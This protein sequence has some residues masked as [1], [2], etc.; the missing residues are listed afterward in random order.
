MKILIF[1]KKWPGGVGV[2]V[3]SIKKELEKKGH[4]V[5]C[6]SR[7]EDLKCSSSV[8]NILWLRKKYKEIIEKENPDI[9]YTQD[10]SMALPLIF[11]FRIFK[12]KHFSCFHGNELGKSK[13]LQTV[14][15]KLLG[16]RLIVVGDSLKKRFSK[17]NL[18]YNGV[19]LDLFKPDKKIKKIKNSVGFVNWKTEDYHY[20]EIVSAC[21]E[22]GKNLILAEKI[23][24]EEMPKFYQKLECFIS[25]PPKVTGFNISWIEAMACQVP[26]IIGNSYGVGAKLSI[27]KVKGFK[28]IKESLEKVKKENYRKEI[29]KSDLTWKNHSNKLLKIWKK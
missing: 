12:R 23:S 11:P 19:D 24:H 13:I 2:V 5:I 26:K 22:L 3:N 4:K 6:T 18:I 14:V 25:L 15:G 21:K 10:W 28:S 8:K 27:E 1:L 16:K 17:S 9:I 29:E 7:E 20:R